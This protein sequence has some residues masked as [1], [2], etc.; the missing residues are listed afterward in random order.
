MNKNQFIPSINFHLWE[1]CNM[2]CKFC[3]ATFQD[4]KQSIL[5][6]GHLPKEDAL[7]LIRQFAD[8]G[9]EKITFV[10][11]EPT[12]C[13]WLDDLIAY[14]KSLGMVTMLVSN[15]TR[16]TSDF[17]LRNRKH[18]DWIALSIDS[19][20]DATNLKTGRAV[21]GKKVISLAAY[22]IL[23]NNI[24]ANAYR[25]KLN[26]VVNRYNYREDFRA[27]INFAAPERWKVLQVLPIKGQND[28]SIADFMISKKQF[29]TFLEKHK[30]VSSLVPET[31]DD[32]K[33][34]YVMVDPAGRLFENSK[35][36]HLYSKPILSVGIKKAI[37]SMNYNYTKFIDRGGLYQFNL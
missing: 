11:G 30:T 9:F 23:I 14:A 35:G 18:L 21:V 4:V 37:E 1:P 36:E 20:Q 15:G 17:L 31:N 5:P 10:G 32:I 6:K 2:R 27:F 25:F 22:K 33:G 7:Q 29:H 8:F 3:F 19:L 12:L 24:K 34:S 26:T 16:L 28:K 13:P